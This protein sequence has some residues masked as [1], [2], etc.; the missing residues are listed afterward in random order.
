MYYNHMTKEYKLDIFETLRAIDKRDYG[1]LDR[2]PEDAKK[3][4]APRVVMRWASSV[5]NGPLSEY[6]IEVIN[7][8]VN[9]NMDALSKHPELQFKLMAL[10]GSGST[11]RHKWI[12]I[13]KTKKTD[14]SDLYDF[15]EQFHPL[16]SY[17]ELT[18]V[19]KMYTEDE[20][21][22]FLHLNGMND[23]ESQHLMDAFNEFNG[24][25]KQSKKS[26]KS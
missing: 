11:Q 19:L 5:N 26:K 9:K 3:A 10:C 16:A 22:D 23:K 7:E 4:F 21:Q 13:A 15:I 8:V 18:Q 2:Q 20:F 25:K 14:S 17:S 1:F 24:V 12:N 6:H